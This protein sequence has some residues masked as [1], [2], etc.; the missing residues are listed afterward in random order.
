MGVRV[1]QLENAGPARG[2]GQAPQHPAKLG[3]PGEALGDRPIDRELQLTVGEVRR[4]IDDRASRRRDREGSA[5]ADV[6]GHERLGPVDSHPGKRARGSARH[7][8]VDDPVALAPQTPQRRGAV[9][10]EHG[11]PANREEGGGLG[12]QRRLGVGP[13]P[14][15]APMPPV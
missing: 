5:D 7:Q 15:D 3:G 10:A 9:V 11:G 8:H 1:E 6:L 12:R 14:I 2:V 4:Q 13:D